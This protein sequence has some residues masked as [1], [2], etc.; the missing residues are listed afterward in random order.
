MAFRLRKMRY[1]VGRVSYD[2]PFDRHDLYDPGQE[3]HDDERDSYPGYG[4]SHDRPDD[5]QADFLQDQR[6]IAEHRRQSAN[7]RLM[8]TGVLAAMKYRNRKLDWYFN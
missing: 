1:G 3:R 4:H 6:D 8:L 7:Q 2:N 5:R